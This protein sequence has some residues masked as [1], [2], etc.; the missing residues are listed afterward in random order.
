MSP[1]LRA[2]VTS[3]VVV[4]LALLAL[5]LPR[6]LAAHG[7]D[8]VLWVAVCVLSEM[9][10]VPTLSG[11][12]TT[13]MASTANLAI[14]M[15]WGQGPSMW[16]AAL[17][18]VLGERLLTRKPKPWV[19]VVFNAA[20]TAITLWA[21]TWVFA[22][23][24]GPLRGFQNAS[25]PPGDFGSVAR[26]ALPVVGLAIGYLI[27]SR[28]LVSVAVAWSTD[29]AYWNVLREDWFHAERL[30]EDS[31]AFLLAPLM[32]I[33]FRAIRYPGVILF[34]VPL[35]MI[36]QSSKR[37][38]ALKNAQS[39]M[40][41]SERMAARGE[42]AAGIAHNMRQQ[43]TAISGHAQMLMK[44]GEAQPFDKITRHATMILDSS[45]SLERLSKAMMDFSHTKLR[46]ERASLNNLIQRSLEVARVQKKAAGVEWVVSLADGLPE[47]EIDQGQIQQV[48]INLMIN[49]VDAMVDAGV[50][51]KVVTI[52]SRFEPRAHLAR[53]SVT[54]TGPGIAPE[55]MG[56]LFEPHFSTK[57]E[58]HGFGL[59]TSYTIAV[60]HGG[61][62][63]AESP[64]GQGATFTLSLRVREGGGAD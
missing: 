61:K 4:A 60:N 57:Q 35:Y 53:V 33:S 10:V 7:L 64:P 58:G 14:A 8:Y 38:I 1:R 19:R 47:M 50:E 29:R 27:V 16:I 56:K 51:R 22:L 44:G 3:T 30:I 63:A 25:V 11:E 43:L 9:M 28:A 32:I 5:G 55:H 59:S 31:A 52:A 24:G 36:Y 48:L 18:T 54:D 42:M 39:Q 41:Q 13:S 23:L 12:G 46:I 17:S 62:L 20:Q 15:L 49:A 37:F 40:I 26:A 34:Y 6:D 45:R 21:A 2:F